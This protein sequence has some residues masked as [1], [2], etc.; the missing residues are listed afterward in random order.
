MIYKNGEDGMR[1][2]V[3]RKRIKREKVIMVV[4]A[5]IKK[6]K[7]IYNSLLVGQRIILGIQ[8]SS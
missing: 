2:M 1:K 7:E 6:T 8:T 3:K 4:A 5:D